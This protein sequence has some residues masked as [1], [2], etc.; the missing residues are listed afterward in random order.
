MRVSPL[1]G[2][3][4]SVNYYTACGTELG[5]VIHNPFER[6]KNG[7]LQLEELA[8]IQREEQRLQTV[9][10]AA[11]CRICL[12]QC[13]PL[14]MLSPLHFLMSSVMPIYPFCRRLQ[15]VRGYN[16]VIPSTKGG[17]K[18]I[19]PIFLQQSKKNCIVSNDTSIRQNHVVNTVFMRARFY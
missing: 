5:R 3:P 12:Q 14:S 6:A 7:L 9:F 16:R 17:E 15:M 13:R 2:W 8:V 4:N 19:T 10:L 11:R 1:F 18:F